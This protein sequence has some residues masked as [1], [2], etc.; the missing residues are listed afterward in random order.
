MG[1]ALFAAGTGWLAF[2][3]GFRARLL[4]TDS[5]VVVV[6]PVLTHYIPIAACADVV[7]GIFFINILKTNGKKVRAWG[8]ARSL[9]EDVA[10]GTGVGLI[11]G[12]RHE[13]LK[14]RG[15]QRPDTGARTVLRADIWLFLLLVVAYGTELAVRKLW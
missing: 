11:D 2:R 8:L 9:I 14:R 12:I 5:E 10:E 6:N 13:I 1:S 3:T 7:A 15:T 4:V